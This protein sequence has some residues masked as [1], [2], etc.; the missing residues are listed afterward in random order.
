MLG[1]WSV[2]WKA[3]VAAQKRVVSSCHAASACMKHA[4]GWFTRYVKRDAHRPLAAACC[5]GP[6][7][8]CSEEGPYRCAQRPS[9]A[10]IMRCTTCTGGNGEWWV[11]G[12]VLVRVCAGKAGRGG[13]RRLGK[14][15][16]KQRHMEPH[17]AHGA[18]CLRERLGSRTKV[19]AAHR[20]S[21]R[22][23]PARRRTSS[24]KTEATWR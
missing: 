5:A 14:W 11:R 1:C 19:S 7:R 13:K 15:A 23:H 17:Q 10:P 4:D 9:N 2:R 24:K 21:G 16:P 3:R 18:D 22:R 12:C 8:R 6:G 20:T